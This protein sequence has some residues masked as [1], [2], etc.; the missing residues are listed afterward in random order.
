MRL[1]VCPEV[2]CPFFPP[3]PPCSPAFPAGLPAASVKVLFFFSVF[4]HLGIASG[5][6]PGS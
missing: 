2:V 6:L 4:M 5:F 3:R 1:S